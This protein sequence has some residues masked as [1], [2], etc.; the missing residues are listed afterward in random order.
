MRGSQVANVLFLLAVPGACPQ[1]PG[2]L[3]ALREL[4]QS[5]LDPRRAHTALSTF[6]TPI[7]AATLP[8]VTSAPRTH[9]A[10]PSRKRPLVLEDP[11]A[12]EEGKRPGGETCSKL[13]KEN[14]GGRRA[15]SSDDS[16]AGNAAGTTDHWRIARLLQQ[17]TRHNVTEYLVKWHNWD[18]TYNEWVP[19]ADISPGLVQVFLKQGTGLS[20]ATA[21]EE[22]VDDTAC[23]VCGG[24]DWTDDN[25][26]VFC[27]QC[28][29]AFHQKCHD[30]PIPD[31]V[32]KS[33]ETWFCSACR[34]SK[35]SV[36]A[37]TSSEQTQK[38]RQRCR[39]APG[40]PSILQAKM[41]SWGIRR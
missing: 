28:E 9:D 29:H 10:V 38:R 7:S 37:K 32:T 23:E 27:D 5:Q 12:D 33:D 19:E 30:P 34:N 35:V 24:V 18:D 26:I 20:D 39:L 8:S 36:R 11:A 16:I 14:A 15:L 41:K 4:W 40:G 6:G 3:E 22:M 1:D 31:E 21:D 17:R 2:S 25:V 13:L